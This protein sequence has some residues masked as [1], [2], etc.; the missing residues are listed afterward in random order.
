MRAK[1]LRGQPAEIKKVVA[2][3]GIR[4]LCCPAVELSMAVFASDGRIFSCKRPKTRSNCLIFVGKEA[5][6]TAALWRF[7]EEFSVDSEAF[8]RFAKEMRV[9]LPRRTADNAL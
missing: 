7:A 9:F 2:A 8:R 1:R 4:L 3:G 5:I 6:Q